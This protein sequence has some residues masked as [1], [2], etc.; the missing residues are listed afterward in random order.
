KDIRMQPRRQFLQHEGGNG[1]RS[2]RRPLAGRHAS[3]FRPR[4]QPLAARTVDRQREIADDRRDSGISLPV[5]R[6]PNH[7]CRGASRHPAAAPSPGGTQAAFDRDHNPWLGEP[8][9]GNERSLTTDGTAEFP[10]QYTPFPTTYLEARRGPAPPTYR[11]A[12]W[13]PDGR[14]ILAV[15][16]DY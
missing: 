5:Y 13:S 8:P 2:G 6:I 9:T 1:A 16:T 11:G 10:S 12:T 7:L 3:G 15:R 14:Y 4:S